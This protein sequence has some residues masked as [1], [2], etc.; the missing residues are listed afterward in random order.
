MTGWGTSGSP[1]FLENSIRVLGIHKEAD[2]KSNKRYGDFI[3]PAIDRIKK[4]L[5]NRQKNRIDLNRKNK[6]HEDLNYNSEKN[7][8]AIIFMTIAQSIIVPLPCN[9]DDIFSSVEKK[10]FKKCP[11]LK[12][13][14][15]IFYLANGSIINRVIS[16]KENKIKDGD[17]ILVQYN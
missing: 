12:K 5:R 13:N 6:K 2:I 7:T 17:T 4:N 3:Y 1:I 11:E 15:D 16:L 14:N 10:L 9:I 8:I